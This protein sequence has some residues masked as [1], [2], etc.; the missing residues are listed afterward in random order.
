MFNSNGKI[1]NKIVSILAIMLLIS[2]VFTSTNILAS[3]PDS[4]LDQHQP[5]IEQGHSIYYKN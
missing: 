3:N 2:T 5:Y 1:N 4:E